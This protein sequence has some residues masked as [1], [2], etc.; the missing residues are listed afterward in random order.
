MPGWAGQL[1]RQIRAS[2]LNVVPNLL[3]ANDVRLS[4][5]LRRLQAKQADQASRLV[6]V[7]ELPGGRLEDARLVNLRW[8]GTIETE[9]VA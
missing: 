3:R 6:R 1:L 5:A 2:F 7:E 9:N 8:V 4:S